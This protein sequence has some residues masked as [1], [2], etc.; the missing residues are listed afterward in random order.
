MMLT[1]EFCLPGLQ[2]G[3][4]GHCSIQTFTLFKWR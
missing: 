2:S 4:V 3:P 1:S